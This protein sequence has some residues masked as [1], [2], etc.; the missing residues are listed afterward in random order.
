MGPCGDR[1]HESSASSPA[2]PPVTGGAG[3]A[4]CHAAAGTCP[5]P[6]SIAGQRRPVDLLGAEHE[7][8]PAAERVAVDQ[9][10]PVAVAHGRDRERR[11]EDGSA[12]SAASAH[13]RHGRAAAAARR[14]RLRRL[15][16][17][18][19][20]PGLAVGQRHDV[21]RADRDRVP[22]DLRRRLGTRDDQHVVT[23]R[24]PR[25]AAT[26]RRILVEY[27]D[28]R[29]RPASPSLERIQHPHHLAARRRG[30]AEHCVEEVGVGHHHEPAAAR[31]GLRRGRFSGSGPG[32]DPGCGPPI[33]A[34]PTAEAV[35]AGPWG[36]HGV[37]HGAAG[38]LRR[39][40][41]VVTP[42][43][44]APG[45]A[46]PDGGAACPVL[47][48]AMSASSWSP[49]RGLARPP[50]GRCHSGWRCRDRNGKGSWELWIGRC[51]GDS[52]APE[53]W[54]QPFLSVHCGSLK[55]GVP[56]SRAGGE[57]GGRRRGV[58][59][60]QDGPR[61]GGLARAV[62]GSAPGG[63]AEPLPGRIRTSQL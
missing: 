7:V 48:G 26:E 53:T 25:L 42:G 22:P 33:A 18:P 63:R 17:H 30:E 38:G 13:D 41:T 9:Q 2:A 14:D 19:D 29:L 46:L 52:S 11:G 31:I 21:C 3:S 23:P 45:G 49:R 24:Q 62:G 1:S 47:P 5:P 59:R 35:A 32:P 16:E 44:R 4:A 55:A 12:R 58:E 10:R 6:T 28:R 36:A 51:D 54:L 39:R 61:Q 34:P 15:G 8:E 20:Q 50:L 40:P 56:H 27:D 43:G 37:G 60:T 57:R